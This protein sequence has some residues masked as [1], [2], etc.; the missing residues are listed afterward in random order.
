MEDFSYRSSFPVA[1]EDLFRW[2]A[3][4]GAFERLAPPWDKVRIVLR[5]GG[6]HDGDRLIFTVGGGAVRLKWEAVHEAYREGKAFTDRQVSGPFAEWVHEHL[7]LED[8][9]DRSVLEDHI[10]YRLPLGVLGRAVAGRRV[11]RRL[12]KTFAFRHARTAADLSRHARYPSTPLTIAISGASGLVGRNLTAFLGG[13]GHRILRLTRRRPAEG[14]DAV[15]WNPAR[16]EIDAAKLEGIDAVVHLAGENISSGRWNA[17]RKEAIRASRV[18]G[19]RLLASALAGLTSP[20]R[21]M[22]CASAIGYYGDRGEEALDEN[23]T[24]GGDFLANVCREWENATRPAAS[25][26]IRVVNLR[27]GVVLA[28]RGGALERMLTPF[29]LGLGGRIGSGRQYMSWISLDDLLGVIQFCLFTEGLS[30]PVNAVAPGAVTNA[31]FTR[32]LGAALNRPAILPVPTA[33]VRALFGE[34]GDALLLSSTRVRPARLL[35]EGFSFLNPELD[36][37]LK[38]E[39]GLSVK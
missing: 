9:P 39:L 23:S 31:A 12:E 17:A 35:D 13:G 34:M 36:G 27:I 32:S 5:E 22:V 1:A 21:V 3:R 28:R 14:E 15:Y 20:P 26:G 4:P 7:F 24:P 8:G 6:L 2:H 30:G 18:E 11:R 37:A 19:T 29:R 10:R 33:A 25:D 38:A 16:G